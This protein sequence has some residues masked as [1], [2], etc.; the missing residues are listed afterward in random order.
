VA[1]GLPPSLS[2]DTMCWLGGGGGGGTGGGEGGGGSRGQ[3][4]K[5]PRLQLT[6]PPNAFLHPQVG[7]S[8]FF[9]VRLHFSPSPL[10]FLSL[11]HVALPVG[12]YA[13][14]APSY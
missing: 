2:V 11:D 5:L 8:H 3:V 6:D 12:L 14:I 1:R 9:H 10:I 4:S 13:L 7:L